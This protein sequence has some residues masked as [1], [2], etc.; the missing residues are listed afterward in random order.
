MSRRQILTDLLAQLQTITPANGYHTNIGAKAEYWTVYPDDYSGPPTVTFYDRQET[1]EKNNFFYNQILE[2]EIQA[3]SYTTPANKLTDSEN[4]HEDLTKAL[5]QTRW[6][7][8]AIIVRPK[9]TEKAIDG[10]G[11]QAISLTYVL[12]IEYRINA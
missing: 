4:L 3:I 7:N 9:E 11:R 6:T 8:A 12:E 10:K 1:S 2:I 5:V